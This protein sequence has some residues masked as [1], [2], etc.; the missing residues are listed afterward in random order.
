VARA[1]RTISSIDNAIG[2]S[3]IGLGLDVLA[4]KNSIEARL[5]T[6]VTLSNTAGGSARGSRSANVGRG[7]TTS[8][9]RTIAIGIAGGA[10]S[11]NV[12][13]TSSTSN[14]GRNMLVQ[15]R[16]HLATSTTVGRAGLSVNS[17]TT[18]GGIGTEREAGI[19]SS[20]GTNTSSASVGGSVGQ[21]AN[22][23]TLT[24]GRSVG[25]GVDLATVLILTVAVGEA[26]SA[27]DVASRGS[28]R[29]LKSA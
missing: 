26:R 29:A 27:R 3:N 11:S 8:G 4:V 25:V 17:A 21:S 7:L 9:L 15:S 1:E 28:R 18:S 10:V 5:S 19:A 2:I 23:I 24:A 16:A 13:D 20:R 12:A 14:A 6:G 22:N